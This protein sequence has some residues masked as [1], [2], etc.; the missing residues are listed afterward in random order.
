MIDSPTIAAD[1]PE[2]DRLQAAVIGEA[3]GRATLA[4][5]RQIGANDWH[6]PTPCSEWDVRTLVSHLVGQCEDGIRLTAMIGRQI[7]GQVRYRGRPGVD[8][9]MA[10][11]VDA[12]RSR[13]G[14][15]LVDL[16]EDL[17]PRAVAARRNRSRPLRALR[18]DP[19]VPGERRWR[20]GYLLDAIYNRDLWMH[21]LDLTRAISQ[22]FVIG[23]HDGQIV[24][25]VIRDLALAWPA[26][27]VVLEL[28]GPA[29]GSWLIGYGDAVA[30]I[31][32][33]A[34]EFMRSLA[35]RADDLSVDLVSGDP[36][37]IAYA[38][39]ARVAF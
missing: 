14:P 38:R 16:F 20:M 34:V 22:P 32:A 17:W 24:A 25:Q 37:V 29:G 35:G 19:G 39:N 33:D 13:P 28:T 21:R 27:P 31:R 4:V 12:H 23:H 18:L 26:A 30:V 9:H 36:A 2:V 8:A 10:M 6:K 1:L 7:V 15:E 5:L 3:E 11:Q